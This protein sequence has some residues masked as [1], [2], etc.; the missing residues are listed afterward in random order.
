MICTSLLLIT[1]GALVVSDSNV[2]V[3]SDNNVLVVSDSN[4]VV[5]FMGWEAAGPLAGTYS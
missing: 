5:V 3:V 2:V 1:W 4:V